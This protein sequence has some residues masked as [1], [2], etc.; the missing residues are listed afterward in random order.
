MLG[1]L[2]ESSL[3]GG[4]AI[5]SISTRDRGVTCFSTFTEIFGKVTP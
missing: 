2:T 3:E 1:G 5:R 4:V